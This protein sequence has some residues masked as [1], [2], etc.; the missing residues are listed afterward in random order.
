MVSFLDI[1]QIAPS[2]DSY[3]DLVLILYPTV[4][5]IVTR[6]QNPISTPLSESLVQKSKV[7]L[8]HCAHINILFSNLYESF[9]D[10]SIKQ[11]L[12]CCH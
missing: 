8:N 3:N 11:C 5:S 1:M 2:P 9:F 12:H 7:E 10:P 6:N 4:E